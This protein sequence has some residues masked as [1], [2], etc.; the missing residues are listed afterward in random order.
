MPRV[1]SSTPT[2]P[3]DSMQPLKIRFAHKLSSRNSSRQYSI[4]KEEDSDSSD[5]QKENIDENESEDSEV[6]KRKNDGH[7][8]A[9]EGEN[10]P[11]KKVFKNNTVSDVVG[12]CKVTQVK[13]KLL[14]VKCCSSR[15]P[16]F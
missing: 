3:Q 5:Q 10:Q 9:E 14:I 8:E 4:V 16:L 15:R 11:L 7:L 13:Y 6:E 2:I 1:S 12:A